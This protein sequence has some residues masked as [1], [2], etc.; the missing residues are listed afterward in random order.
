MSKATFVFSDGNRPSIPL[1]DIH[2]RNLRI[3][4]RYPRFRQEIQGIALSIA[5]QDIH[6]GTLRPAL[7]ELERWELISRTNPGVARTKGYQYTIT[8]LGLKAL[9]EF[10]HVEQEMANLPPQF[11]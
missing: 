6:N 4:S 9:Q 11:A 1:K 2:V 8:P 3:L 7:E 5:G 10:D